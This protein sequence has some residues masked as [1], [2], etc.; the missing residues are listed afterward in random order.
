[1]NIHDRALAIIDNY[2]P[3]DIGDDRFGALIGDMYTE[4][5]GAGTTCGFL[6]SRLLFDLGVR[7]PR[8]VNRNDADSGLKYHIGENISRLVGG[9]K[10]LGAWREG[11]EGIKPGDIYFISN[12]PPASEHVGVFKRQ[13][14]DTHWETADAGQ[15]NSEGRQAA[16]FVTRTFDGSNLGTPNGQKVIQGY[17]DLDALPIA[18]PT[19]ATS[20]KGFWVAAGLLAAGALAGAI[21]W[22]ARKR[23]GRS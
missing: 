14:D 17:V 12:G 8:I 18:V 9:A 23:E 22:F 7:D 11:A 5:P 15:R 10:A 2:V 20:G 4:G 19:P 21:A 6:V 3:S 16:R 1:M 13:L